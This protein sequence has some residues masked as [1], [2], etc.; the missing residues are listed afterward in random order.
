MEKNLTV[1]RQRVHTLIY[2]IKL[3]LTLPHTNLHPLTAPRNITETLLYAFSLNIGIG[4]E[5]NMKIKS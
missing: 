4:L 5:S 2:C 1:G 3:R